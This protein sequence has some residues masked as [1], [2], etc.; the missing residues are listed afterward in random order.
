MTRFSQTNSGRLPLPLSHYSPLSSL[1]LLDPPKL[2]SFDFF[3]R[4]RRWKIEYSGIRIHIGSIAKHGRKGREGKGSLVLCGEKDSDSLSYSKPVRSFQLCGA[5]THTHTHF[6]P[7]LSSLPLSSRASLH[8][9]DISL[10]RSFSQS[11][12]SLISFEPFAPE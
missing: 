6:S 8:R 5:R 11:E 10:R 7:S 4:T 2:R 3:P 12:C 1:L 9:E